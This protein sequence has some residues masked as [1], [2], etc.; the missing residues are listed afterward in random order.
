MDFGKL[1]EGSEFLERV[2]FK[3]EKKYRNLTAKEIKI[4]EKNGNYSSDW[5]KVKVSENFQPDCIKNSYF[6][7]EILLGSFS[8]YDNYFQHPTGIYNSTLKDCE[9]GDNVLIK[10][11]SFL[12]NY[13]VRKSS[14]LINLGNVI[15]HQNANFGIGHPLVLAIETGGREV[16]T[17]PEIDVKLATLI[18]TK[19]ELVP[20]YENF[21]EKYLDKIEKNK[22]IIDE[23]AILVNTPTIEDSYIGVAS[24]IESALGV[25]NSTILSN[26][27][28]ETEI[29]YGGF[30]KNSIIQWG[31]EITTGGICVNSVLCEHSHCERHGKVTESLIA[32]NSG[33]AEGEVTS[34][35]VGPFVGFHHQA[36]LIAAFWP[37]GKGNVGYGANVGSNHTS[38]APDQE[39]W[40]GEG[41]FFGLGVNIKYPSDF[42][43][44]PYSIIATGV[45][46]LPQKIT[47]P[48]S[49]INN[50]ATSLPGVSPAFNEIIPGWVLS[51]NIYTIKRNEGKYQK[52][53]KAKRTRFNFEVFRPE[54]IDLMIE[55][56][57]T[58]M[59][60]KEI[61]EFYLEKDIPG[62]GKNYLLE[63]NRK[64]GIEIYSFYIKYYAASGL[65][66]KVK[67]IIQKG[68]KEKLRDILISPSDDIRWEH[69]R[70]I[71][72]KEFSGKNIK[73]I[74]LS[75]IEMEE[76]IAND[77]QIS[78]EKD[79]IR[80]S[81]IIPDYNSIHTLA[82]NDS[83]VKE[84][85]ERFAKVKKEIEDIINFI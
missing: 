7:G 65:L 27:G 13:V 43:R 3:I 8:G 37:E 38:K 40:I 15:T 11:V 39:I 46:T 60:V 54:I 9:I 45:T 5:K 75:L 69:E 49:L 64:K 26:Q 77:T 47:F 22:G 62:I 71:L 35:L 34:S 14:V 48:F 4:L 17:F 78:K 63:E 51:D 32:P 80:G 41:V 55:A 29:S 85:W 82:E 23:Y 6:L 25:I 10:N 66:R 1:L 42:S 74:L 79:D 44:A 36:L 31:C 2:S 28:E 70:K 83:F 58:L 76:K 20:D 53:N 59:R 61:K 67:E 57:E 12:S 56:C 72:E 24:K 18:A 19:R 68:E 52:R 21:I 50:P 30:V 81:R 16:K 73:E 84:T 33:V